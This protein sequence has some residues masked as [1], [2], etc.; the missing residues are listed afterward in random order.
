MHEM[1]GTV[2]LT[3][4]SN[5]TIL[6]DIAQFKIPEEY[7]NLRCVVIH[8]PRVMHMHPDI[9][10]K[11]G[12]LVTCVAFVALRQTEPQAANIEDA[13]SRA[14]EVG[15]QLI[16]SVGGGSTMD[17]GKGVSQ[18][19]Y[20]RRHLPDSFERPGFFRSI[21]P[22][23]AIPTTAGPGAEVSPAMVFSNKNGRRIAIVD[24]RLIPRHVVIV[25]RLATTLPPY[26]TACC[27]LDGIAHSI[28]GALR[29]DCSP[30][31]YVMSTLVLRGFLGSMWSACK[32]PHDPAIRE[33]LGVLSVW[34]SESLR[35]TGVGAAH[36]LA[37]SVSDAVRAPHGAIVSSALVA[38]LEGDSSGGEGGRQ[39]DQ[40]AIDVGYQDARG[41]TSFIAQYWSNFV[42]RH[43]QYLRQS[44]DIDIARCVE[45]A[46]VN[47]RLAFHPSIL[48]ALRIERAIRRILGAL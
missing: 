31:A 1:P 38:L 44:E 47:P 39:L 5:I 18:L 25:P 22:H 29:P 2:H 19:L 7:R 8:D 10:E 33:R 40:L 34:S 35:M 13:A 21:A 9:H 46:L 43:G 27:V 4:R 11:L 26:E 41:L 42:E 20:G 45:R 3:A 30:A 37:D 32:S 24:E 12:Q 16:V 23:I 15:A 48:D 36:A 6:S 17:T 28:E 14:K